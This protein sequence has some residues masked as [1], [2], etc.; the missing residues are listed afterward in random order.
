[1]RRAKVLVNGAYAGDL[2][3]VERGQKYVFLYLDNYAGPSVSL[4]MP[5]SRREYTFDRFPPFFE[6]L[7]PEGMMLEGLLRQIK[8][9]RTD[10]MSQL[11][12]VGADL[13]GHVTVEAVE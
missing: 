9:D 10:Y 7:L 4:S 5:N 3:E 8:A 6:G 13:V 2:V 1:M 12:A 11:I